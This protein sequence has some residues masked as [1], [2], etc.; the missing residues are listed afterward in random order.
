MLGDTLTLTLP[1]GGEKVLNKINQDGYT[2]EYFLREA[3]QEFTARVRHTTA[4]AGGGLE[5]RDRHNVEITQKIYATS[6]A[7]EIV[8]KFYVV[9]E[10]YDGD[11]DTDTIEALAAWLVSGTILTQLFGWQS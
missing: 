10:N 11:A 2:S 7:A 9:F 1:V 8:R 3:T 4:K 5:D 6:S